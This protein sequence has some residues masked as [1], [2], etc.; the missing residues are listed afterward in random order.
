MTSRGERLEEVLWGEEAIVAEE[1]DSK[2][3]VS[4]EK[5]IKENILKLVHALQ[6]RRA[7]EKE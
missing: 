5:E 2:P 7:E 1:S 4:G 3:V 6:V